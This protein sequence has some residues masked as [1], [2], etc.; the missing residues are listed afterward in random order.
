MEREEFFKI[1]DNY[2]KKLN[3]VLS[4]T[5]KNQFYDYMNLLIEWNEKINLTAIINPQEIIIK[6]FTDSITI[7]RY[8]EKKDSVADIGTGAGFPGIPLKIIRPELKIELVDSLNKRINFL[9]IVIDKL[10]LNDILATHS[11][12]EEFGRNESKR[13]NFDIVTSRAVANLNVLSE[14]MLPLAKIGGRCI[15]MKG[16][17][18]LD[19]TNKSKNAINILGGKLSNIEEFNLPDTNIGR[20][21][22]VIDKVK[23]TPIKYPRKPGLPSKEPIE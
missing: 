3:V 11:R 2:S 18:V 20:S 17:N 23:N 12:I 19:E 16:P 14:Y 9:N 6:H 1:I 8:I 10:N 7:S 15:C 13:E 5:Q 22:V 4:A 21:I